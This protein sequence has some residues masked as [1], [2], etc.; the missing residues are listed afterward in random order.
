MSDRTDDMEMGEDVVTLLSWVRTH[1]EELIPHLEDMLPRFNGNI[2]N[3][4]D[5]SV[6]IWTREGASAVQGLIDFLTTV[7]PIEPLGWSESLH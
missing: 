3:T 5:N 4:P 7:E 1:P 6:N 2:Y